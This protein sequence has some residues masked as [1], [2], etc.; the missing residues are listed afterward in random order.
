MSDVPAVIDRF[1][2]DWRFL[3]N[4]APCPWITFEEDVYPTVEHAFQAAK[5]DN[6]H[7]RMEIRSARQPGHAKR[8]GRSISPLPHGW[9]Q[10]RIDVMRELLAQKFSAGRQPDYLAGLLRT[11]TAQLI[12]SNEWGD[13]FWG[14]CDG[15]GANMLGILLMELRERRQ[16]ET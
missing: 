9:G 7:V 3:S 6:Y 14:V 2:G 15:V 8:M 13:R 10:T 1:M 4:F 11:G 5:T 16:G 12:E